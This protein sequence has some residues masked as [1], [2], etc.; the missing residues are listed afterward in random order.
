MNYFR[1]NGK[2]DDTLNTLRYIR[3]NEAVMV[4]EDIN[5]ENLPPTEDAA[6]YHAL[7]V[8]LQYLN[9]LDLGSRRADG[10]LKPIKTELN[11]APDFVLNVV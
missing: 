7:R 1:Y 5:P 4:S 11:A 6:N 10:C 9:P 8:H 3:W 2:H